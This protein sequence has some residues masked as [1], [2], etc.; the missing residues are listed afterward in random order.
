MFMPFF[1]DPLHL[2]IMGVGA[3]M[4]FLP[5]QWVKKTVATYS[6]VRNHRGLRGRDVATQILREHGLS[7]VS[8]ESVDG[9]LSDHYD[10]SALAV[11]LSPDIY[12]GDSIASVAI[13]AHECGHAIQ[14]AKGYTPVVLRSSLAPVVGLGSQLGPM[15]L[16][17]SV[18]LGATN[19]LM[20]AWAWMLAWV[21]VAVYGIAVAFQVVTL[22]V[23]LDAS[24]RALKVLETQQ[25]L[26]QDEMK[27]AKKVLTAAAFTYVAAA[28]YALMELLYWVFRLLNNRRSNN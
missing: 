12:N 5:Q 22:P 19:H 20:P 1:Y 16:M 2:L 23:E 14:H 11:R 13:A 8:V 6:E 21:G 28:L 18:G 27:G 7:N 24:G 4:V 3:V 17:V 26:N 10:P 25:Y 15:L 9:F